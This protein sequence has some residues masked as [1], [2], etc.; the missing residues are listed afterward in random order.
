VKDARYRF[1][2]N[3]GV[4][5]RVVGKDEIAV[6]GLLSEGREVK[7]KL[8]PRTPKGEECA[9]KH[10]SGNK[11]QCQKTWKDLVKSHPKLAAEYKT[12]TKH[13]RKPRCASFATNSEVRACR[14]Y[15]AKHVRTKGEDDDADYAVGGKPSAG[16]DPSAPAGSKVIK[17]DGKHFQSLLSVCKE[18]SADCSESEP[19]KSADLARLADPTNSWVTLPTAKPADDVT[20][21]ADDD[22]NAPQK[23]GSEK[24]TKGK[25]KKKKSETP[26]QPAPDTATPDSTSPFVFEGHSIKRDLEK[27][28]VGMELYSS[29]CAS[30]QC[31]DSIKPFMGMDGTNL[32]K[33][34][35]GDVAQ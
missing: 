31:R 19:I 33:D 20:P 28:A 11:D 22:Q 6:K 32:K 25:H 5:A 21:S 23:P 18:G 15:F 24:P 4:I 8:N 2:G 7:I 29:C 27:I 17:Y 9:D 30:S 10:T 35:D 26:D 14:A 16:D 13:K 1:L 12:M 34:K 3:K